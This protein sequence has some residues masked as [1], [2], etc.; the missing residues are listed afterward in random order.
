MLRY[1]MRRLL[2]VVVLLFAISVLT[3]VLFFMLPGDPAAGALKGATP[4]DRLATPS[5]G[6]RPAA[7]EAVPELPLWT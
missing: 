7:V 4:S 2:W 5:H 3:F 6:S 1:V